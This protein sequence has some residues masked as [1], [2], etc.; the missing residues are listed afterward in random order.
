[1]ETT[2][3][4]FGIAQLKEQIKRVEELLSCTTRNKIYS[5]S[6]VMALLGVKDKLIKKYRDDGLS[7]Y[8]QV[9]DKFWYTQNDVDKFLARNYYAAYREAC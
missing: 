3:I 8:T 4:L 6:E 1:M 2:E 7:A 9:G 5:N